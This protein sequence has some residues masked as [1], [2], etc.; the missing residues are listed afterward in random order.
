MIRP[1]LAALL[2]PLL[3]GCD[4]A[5][6]GPPSRVWT[7]FDLVGASETTP[8]APGA[9]ELVPGG[10]PTG[11]FIVRSP[12]Q[13]DP[14]IPVRL[15]F[16][17]KQRAAYVTTEVWGNFP[18]V[19]LQP[20]YVFVTGYDPKTGWMRLKENGVNV[21]AV[22]SVGPNS[23]F[24]SPFW[25]VSY[26][27]VPDGTPSTKYQSV[28]AILDAK[29]PLFPGPGRLCVLSPAGI[30]VDITTQPAAGLLGIQVGSPT[31]SK[32]WV[33]GAEVSVLD[34]GADRFTWD[35]DLVIHDQPLF[36]FFARGP[37][38]TWQF[39]G[40]PSVGGPGG[41]PPSA[42]GNRPAFGSLWRLVGVKLGP[43]AG[44]ALPD[45]TTK[46]AEHMVGLGIRVEKVDPKAEQAFK[47]TANA[48]CFD[49]GIATCTFL[50]SQ[51]EIEKA[52]P[53]GIVPSQILVTCPFVT[54]NGMKVP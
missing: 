27:Q 10:M 39:T 6:P 25:K 33:D 32:G 8:V 31:P 45:P 34:F 42:P 20:M 18:A 44:I 43:G 19:W 22:F 4:G 7:L 48:A 50:D 38:G 17:D 35:D 3:V 5:T 23:R 41:R 51:A 54:F 29:L 46:D 30:P 11:A 13:D 52:V 9:F 21:G 49:A 15:A 53:T 1:G 40:A 26:V 36:M 28:R 12:N 2:V 24:Y 16:H 14:K 47:V 37:D